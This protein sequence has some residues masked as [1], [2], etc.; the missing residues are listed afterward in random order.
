MADKKRPFEK[1]IVT[2]VLKN[3]SA[4]VAA[5]EVYVK[6]STLSRQTNLK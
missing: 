6:E 3:D 4:V 1:A 5:E 2:N